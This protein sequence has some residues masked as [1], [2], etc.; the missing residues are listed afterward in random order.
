M[1]RHNSAAARLRRPVLWVAALVLAAVGIVSAGVA[2]AQREP[3]RPPGSASL[4]AAATCDR[5]VRVVTASSFAP[6]LAALQPGL[7]RGKDCVALDTVVV[8]GRAAADRVAEREADVWIPDDV[9]WAA[10][11]RGGLLADE[12]QGDSG[13]VLATSPIYMVD[14]QG[15][16]GEGDRG[17]RL[18]ARPGRPGRHARPRASGWPSATR[19][20][21]AT[22]WSPP[23]AS[24]SRS[25]SSAGWTPRPRRCR[26]R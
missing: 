5:S 24:A 13:T 14:R 20:G 19:T 3:D 17:R 10:V 23:A 16:R 8:D 11:A 12:G 18:L 4:L 7:A 1:G 26:P 15:H 6:V 25:G 2:V 9:S 22:G 21:P